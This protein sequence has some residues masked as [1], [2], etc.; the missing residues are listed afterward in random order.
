MKETRGWWTLAVVV[1]LVVVA[2]A[3][4]SA[5]PDSAVD[6]VSPE[7]AY[8]VLSENSAAIV[9]DIRTPE[10][11]AENRIE[12]AVNID[13]YAADFEDR[14]AALDRDANYVMYCRSGNR[15]GQARP[16]FET[17]GFADVADV[18]GGIVAW[19]E[20]GLPVESG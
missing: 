11:F 3:A 1:V 6:V 14:I 9:L 8:D 4:C 19:H 12:G 7:E 18:D 10:E 16:V 15:S 2:A 20:A 13:F 5:D 17:L